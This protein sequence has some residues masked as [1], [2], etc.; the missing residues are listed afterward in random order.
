MIE[1]SLPRVPALLRV[2]SGNLFVYQFFLWYFQ[3]KRWDIV[4]GFLLNIL[5]RSEYF[6]V[7]EPYSLA[8]VF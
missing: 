3:S 6:K 2:L 5:N 7:P 1:Y 8:H 4:V